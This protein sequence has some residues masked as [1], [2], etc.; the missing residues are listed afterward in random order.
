MASIKIFE[1]RPTGFE[2]FD[3]SENFL[4][5]LTHLEIETIEGGDMSIVTYSLIGF[6][7]LENNIMESN[8]TYS[9]GISVNTN[10]VLTA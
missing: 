10:A 2:L 5:E 1:L 7:T 3:D 9:V 4:N 8:Y 6:S